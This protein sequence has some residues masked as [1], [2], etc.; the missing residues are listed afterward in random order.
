LVTLAVLVAA[1]LVLTALA[2]LLV[3]RPVTG[4]GGLGR[5]G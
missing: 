5:V 2:G 3:A 4:V 1:V